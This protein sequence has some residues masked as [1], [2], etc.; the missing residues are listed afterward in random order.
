MLHDL[1]MEIMFKNRAAFF[2]G[3][4]SGESGIWTPNTTFTAFPFLVTTREKIVG[5]L[6]HFYVSVHF[7][8]KPFLSRRLT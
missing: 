4:K 1:K 3:G 8:R 5:K 2:E 7:L 6:S